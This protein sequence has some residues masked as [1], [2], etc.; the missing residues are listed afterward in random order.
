[1]SEQDKLDKIAKEMEKAAAASK[2][3][4]DAL[5]KEANIIKEKK[6][7]LDERARLNAEAGLK[8]VAIEYK[9]V[10][11][12]VTCGQVLHNNEYISVMGDRRIC[13]EKIKEEMKTLGEEGWVLRATPS[14]RDEYNKTLPRA[15]YEEDY[16]DIFKT[17]IARS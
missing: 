13:S 4:M 11:A 2:A 3:R 5:M 9:Y 14:Y 17:Y 8:H 7:K 15:R 16:V 6:I 1:M 12:S 10:D